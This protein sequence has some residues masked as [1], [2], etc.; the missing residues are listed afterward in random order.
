ME[1][2]G[3]KLSIAKTIEG[4]KDEKLFTITREI[5]QK[6]K[7]YAGFIGVVP[8][9]SRVKGYATDESDYDYWALFDTDITNNN[10]T[11]NLDDVFDDFDL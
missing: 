1:Q 8:F 5:E 9:G 4:K 6:L 10:E 7:H 2:F 3:N 11:F